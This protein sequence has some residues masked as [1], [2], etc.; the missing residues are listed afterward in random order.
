ME[1]KLR[2]SYRMCTAPR[3][4]LNNLPY[5][6]ALKNEEEKKYDKTTCFA[7]LSHFIVKTNF[8]MKTECIQNRISVYLLILKATDSEMSERRYRM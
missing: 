4:R 1:Y 7:F 6:D 8:E 2:C 5:A 3:P